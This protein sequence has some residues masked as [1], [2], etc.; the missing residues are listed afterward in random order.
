MAS[1]APY[2]YA[3]RRHGLRVGNDDYVRA[4]ESGAR[5]HRRQPDARRHVLVAVDRNAR[6]DDRL[7]PG[8]HASARAPARRRDAVHARAGGRW[9]DAARLI[10]TS[11]GGRSND[12]ALPAAHHVETGDA[13]AWEGTAGLS[14]IPALVEG[15]HL[16][17]ARSAGEYYRHR[18]FHGAPEDVD[19]AP[20]S[21]DGYAAVMAFVALEDW[22]TAKRVADWML[23]FRYTYVA[24]SELTLLGRYGFRTVGADQASPPNQHLH[25]FGLICVPEMVRLARA[26]GDDYYLGRT[27][28][29]PRLLPPVHRAGRRRLRRAGRNGSERYHQTD[30][31]AA[32]GC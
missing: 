26:V 22:E 16:E 21:E 18:R 9:E 23:T 10:S 1:G 5:P 28:A 25:A 15:G 32:R 17:E 2:A 14:W 7:A 4:A 8:P 30:C 31:F 3:L 20:T 24:F 13:V 19:L 29:N 12:G 6:L 27:R 11:C